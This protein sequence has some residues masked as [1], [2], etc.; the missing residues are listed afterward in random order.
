AAKEL[1]QFV[2]SM[3]RIGRGWYGITHEEI[4]K[5]LAESEAGCVI[6][7]NPSNLIK[8]FNHVDEP[9]TQNV[10]LYVLPEHPIIKHSLARLQQRQALESDPAKRFVTP[11]IFESTLGDRQIDEFNDLVELL[12]HPNIT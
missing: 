5:R 7:E 1:G 4:T 2:L 10:L 11:D 12:Q 3:L 8:L 9:N 6:E